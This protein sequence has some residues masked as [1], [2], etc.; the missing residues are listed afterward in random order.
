MSFVTLQ[1]AARVH[2]DDVRARGDHLAVTPGS[3]NRSAQIL[4]A[5]LFGVRVEQAEEDDNCG[6]TKE[7]GHVCAL[8]ECQIFSV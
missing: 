1:A 2:G 4:C 7:D 3:V 8:P 5:S 6:D